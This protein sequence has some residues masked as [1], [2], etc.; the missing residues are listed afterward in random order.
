M[1]RRP[2]TKVS[3]PPRK[4][5]LSLLGSREV[6]ID[7]QIVQV[8]GDM[9]WLAWPLATAL[10]ISGMS[11]SLE[12]KAPAEN[13]PAQT[14]EQKKAAKIKAE[15]AKR[16]V[17]EKARVR[18]KLRDG[19]ELKGYITRIEED[20]FELQKDPDKLDPLPA[21]ERLLSIS[22]ADVVKIRGPRSRAAKIGVDVG[23]TILFVAIVAGLILLAIIKYN[24]EHD[25]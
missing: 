1:I 14:P 8:G 7:A 9:K 16:G 12:T 10:A 11:E 20:S 5:R 6:L 19:H 17:G 13:A 25:Y 23:E 22:Y 21:K 24:H 15:V 3:G 2:D 4:E 18:V